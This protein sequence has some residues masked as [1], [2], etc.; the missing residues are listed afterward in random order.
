MSDGE[1]KRLSIVRGLTRPKL[2]SRKSSGTNIIPRD[3]PEVEIQKESFAAD[4]ARAMSPR[5]SSYETEKLG[6]DTRKAVQRYDRCARHG[7][8]EWGND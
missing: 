5:R 3:H 2:A 6:L 8:S 7:S 1:P 4:D